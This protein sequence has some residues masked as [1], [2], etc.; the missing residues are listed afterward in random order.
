MKLLLLHL[1]QGQV[2]TYYADLADF[3]ICLHEA[4]R[5]NSN[6]VQTKKQFVLEEIL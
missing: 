3:W 6:D 1:K 4:A 5:A 2:P